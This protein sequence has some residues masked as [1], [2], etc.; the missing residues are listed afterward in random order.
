MITGG[1]MKDSVTGEAI[2]VIDITGGTIFLASNLVVPF[3]TGGGGG[4]GDTKE[5][6]YTYFTSAGRQNTFRADISTLPTLTDIEASTILAK[7]TTVAT[8]A[9]QTSVDAIPTNPL[10]STDT[11]LNN[12]DATISSRLSTANGQKINTN[13][14]KASKLIPA[15]ETF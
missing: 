3:T 15:S 5:D 2:D 7:E 6:I 11:I 12:L 8:R 4:G 9:S 10:L 13:T 14:I 1:Y